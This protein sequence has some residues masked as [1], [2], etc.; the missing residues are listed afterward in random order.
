MLVLLGA[1]AVWAGEAP[2][3][4]GLTTVASVR[5]LSP[6]KA[7]Q[8]LALHLRGV[9]TTPN[10]WSNS[11]FFQDQTAGIAVDL[12]DPKPQ[13]KAGDLVDIVGESAPG[14]FAPSVSATSVQRV[15]R[16]DFPKSR[17]YRMS[18]LVGGD[19]DS[20][21][22]EITG[23]VHTAAV[24][25][26]QHL[27]APVLLLNVD[28]GS[29]VVPVQVM[30]YPSGDFRSLI[31]AVVRIR[32][33]CATNYNDRRQLVGIKLAAPNMSAITILTP[34][35]TNPFDAP[36]RPLNGLLQFG[37]GSAPFH[38]LRVRGTVT[39]QHP[40]GSLYPRWRLGV[41]CPLQNGDRCFTWD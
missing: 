7:A 6:E 31:D 13:F 15:G 40:G 28:T 34:G 19:E 22:I 33:V 17:L 24:E 16:G 21:W 36:L 18:E 12:V 38:R 37:Q 30:D 14:W 39:F 11:F 27:R 35:N 26:I 25:Q 3:S 41:A 29:G 32:G 4:A 10:G 5:A 2:P 20:Q 9:V 23:L 1:S 8:H